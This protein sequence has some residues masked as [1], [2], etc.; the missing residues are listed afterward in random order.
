MGKVLVTHSSSQSEGTVTPTHYPTV[1][2]TL[3][4]NLWYSG[5]NRFETSLTSLKFRRALLLRLA[6][7]WESLDDSMML[8]SN[9]STIHVLQSDGALND[10]C[11][12]AVCSPNSN[13]RF[14]LLD[15]CI[16]QL[17]RVGV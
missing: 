7:C 4:L 11:V 2:L 15:P 1:G 3:G 16:L 8:F 17:R 13:M 12:C 14:T 10:F 6:V 5:Y 9:R